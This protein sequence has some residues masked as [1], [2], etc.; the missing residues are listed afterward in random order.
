MKF[1]SFADTEI[2]HGA[3]RT[4]L[5]EEPESRDNFVIQLDEFF[6]GK[7]INIDLARRF[8]RLATLQYCTGIFTRS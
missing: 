6:F 8:C 5:V 1:H 7:R 2:Q 3:V 4:H